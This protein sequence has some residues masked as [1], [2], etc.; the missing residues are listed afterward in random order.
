MKFTKLALT[1][2]CCTALFC[3][4]TKDSDV[5]IKVN[6]KGIT[7]AEFSEDFNRIKNAELKNAPKELQKNNSYAVLALKNRYVN[8]VVVR[9][10]L[11]QEFEK[12]KLTA[13]EEEIKAKKEFLVKQIGSEELFNKILKENDISEE[14]L[15]S[16][17]A[18]EVK[19]D[20][21]V[22]SLANVKITDADAEKFYKE[23]KAEFTLPERV[24][25]SH[26]LFE[27]NI[28]AIK[29]SIADAD[30][31]ANLTTEAIE[32]KAKEQLDKNLALAQEVQKK[33]SKN[34][35]NFAQL[36]KEYSQDKGS[37]QNGGDLGFITREQVVK[38]FGDAAFSQKVG[39]VSPL[40][41]SQFGT[42]IIYV[43]DKAAKETQSFSK[44][45]ADI[46]QFLEKRQKIDTTRELIVGLKNKATIEFVDKSLDPAN[47]QKQLEKAMPGPKQ[48]KQE[49]KK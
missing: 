6:D 19:M 16:D 5:V 34:P 47:I 9:E 7:K 33:A 44:V 20:K 28:E 43:R 8:D 11:A 22:A 32:K 41:K 10:L 45:K 3:G 42:H 37:A 36:A 12:R 40:V 27:T 2:L 46:K 24:Q 49:K 18:K 21:L 13:S 26:I 31:N 14:K 29:K 1:L 38:E 35:K 15:N 48:Q 25:A 17:M 23:N 39:T 4:C 30:K